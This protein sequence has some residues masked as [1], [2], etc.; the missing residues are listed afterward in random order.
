MVRD[1]E[2][3]LGAQ[4]TRRCQVHRILGVA[5]AQDTR[6]RWGQDTRKLWG[7]RLLGVSGGTGY[8]GTLD[9][10]DTRG[11]CRHRIVKGSGSTK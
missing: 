6:G 8:K 7:H 4:D 1:T 3:A 2:E 11:C 5:G 9:A 10:Q